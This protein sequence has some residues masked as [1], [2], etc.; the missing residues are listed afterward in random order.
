MLG[1]YLD[2]TSGNSPWMANN[3]SSKWFVVCVLEA[4][5]Q[6]GAFK[7]DLVAT[8]HETL[9]SYYETIST[10]TE[11]T[12]EVGIVWSFCFKRIASKIICCPSLFFSLGF[13]R[14]LSRCVV[15]ALVS[16]WDKTLPSR[17]RHCTLT[18]P[19]STQCIN[20]YL[21]R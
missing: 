14:S 17:A 1:K 2:I 4:W 13:L 7:P 8:L 16:G 11:T 3:N 15:T 5:S 10:G 20:G 21:R 19:L 18:V 12:H 6:S 9:K